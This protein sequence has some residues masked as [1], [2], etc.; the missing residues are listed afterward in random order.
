MST[1]YYYKNGGTVEVNPEHLGM[2]IG[3]RPNADFLGAYSIGLTSAVIAA[4]QLAGNPL[5]KFRWAHSRYY[6]IPTKVTVSAA[7]STTGFGAGAPFGLEV[8]RGTS[9]TQATNGGGSAYTIIIPG[10]NDCKRRTDFPTTAFN[11][12]GDIFQHNGGISSE[13]TTLVNDAQA[14]GAYVGN[15]PTTNTGTT[16]MIPPGTV[17]W[18]RNSHDEFPVVLKQNEGLSIKVVNAGPAT[19]TWQA[20]ATIDWIE[21]DPTIHTG[22]L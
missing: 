8:R 18:Q 3:H 19:G 14:L 2:S 10:T 21:I 5:F 4:G 22:W 7:V 12:T 11:T 17:L 9:W 15:T 6:C 20:T 1:Q 16:Q 13:T